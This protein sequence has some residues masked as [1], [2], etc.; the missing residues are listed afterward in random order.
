MVLFWIAA[1]TL[2]RISASVITWARATLPPAQMTNPAIR[3]SLKRIAAYSFGF[4]S[5]FRIP[6]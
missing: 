6:V 5:M 2:A 4:G 3:P 1:S